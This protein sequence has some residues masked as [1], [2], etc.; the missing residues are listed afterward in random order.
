VLSCSGYHTAWSDAGGGPRWPHL[1]K[2]YTG[3]QLGLTLAFL[4]GRNP[5]SADPAV[6]G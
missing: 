4:L 3:H 6:T 2:P 1:A 5:G